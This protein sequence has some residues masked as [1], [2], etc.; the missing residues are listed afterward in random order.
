M[1]KATFTAAGFIISPVYLKGS[2]SFA[3]RSS[4]FAM[5]AI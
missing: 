4:L 5:I 1:K 3:L 2:I